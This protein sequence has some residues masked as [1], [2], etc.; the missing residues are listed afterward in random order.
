MFA[1]LDQLKE[2]NK[3]GEI[4]LRSEI[5]NNL[6][7]IISAYYNIAREEKVLDVMRRNIEISEERVSFAQSEKEV[8]TASKF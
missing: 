5:E 4:N 1:S 6:A 3:L 8:G 2:L 7:E